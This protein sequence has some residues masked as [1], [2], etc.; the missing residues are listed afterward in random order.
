MSRIAALTKR[1]GVAATADF[2]RIVGLPRRD[3]DNDELEHF[4][5]ELTRYL[6]PDGEVPDD[7]FVLNRIQ[8]AAL[9]DIHD[10]RG[11]FLPVAVGGGKALISLLAPVV[12]EAERPLLL[13]PA[14]LREQT[15]RKV[16]PEMARMFRLHP[17][18]LVAGNS[19]L[20]LAK[21]ADM[22]ERLAPDVIILDEVHEYK[23][24]RAGRTRRMNR[25]LGDHPETVVVAMSG[26]VS[27]RSLRDYHH[28]I[29]WC[30]GENRMPL[31]QKH[32][33]LCDWADAL[34]V[35]V[36]DEKRLAPGAMRLFCASGENARQ[37]FRRR[38]TETPGVVA[39]GA[40][41]LGVSLRIRA[42]EPRLPDELRSALA[43]LRSR[44]EDPN[45]VSYSEAVDIW[46]V[47]RQ[48]ALGFWY[49]WE[50]PAPEGW[51]DARRDWSAFVRETIRY[52]RRGLDTELQVWNDCARRHVELKGR[53]TE[54]SWL[55]WRELRD[56]FKPNPVPTWLDERWLVDIV[57]R[58]LADGD[59]LVWIEHTAVGERL[60][61]AIGVP[62]FGAGERASRDILDA[63]GPAV[64]SIAA[65]HRGKNLQQWNRNLV[66]A[67]PSSGKM[68]E[69]LVG[70]T[71]RVGQRADEVLVDVMLHYV[72]ANDSF[73]HALDDARYLEDTLGSRQRLNYADI[74]FEV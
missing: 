64:V 31:P 3:W 26:T 25:F 27:S 29:R 57:K 33:E 34:D 32:M 16:L 63:D 40:E 69:Q 71:H 67:P 18:L 52:N 66:V 62:Y 10:E 45:G 47:A 56:T 68:W 9:R 35:D 4:R 42:L 38:L 22:L 12:L 51:K 1:R 2:R 46:R 11:G 73:R 58:W 70:R 53:K 14:D 60:S 19:E 30:L 13:L 24:L 23:N 28:I 8:A 49:R 15:K 43:T 59:G 21:N 50:P 17:N 20:S 74:A 72:E 48:L 54:P 41:E 7:A 44:W 55:L 6:R 36:P 37:G 5:V 39:S 65:H 61:R